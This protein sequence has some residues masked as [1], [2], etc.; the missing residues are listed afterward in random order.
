MNYYEI[1]GVDA[2][3][4]DVEIKKAYRKLAV[5]Y[6]PDVNSGDAANEEKFKEITMAYDTLSNKDKRLKYD[7]MLRY[8]GS[9]NSRFN[10]SSARGYEDFQDFNPEDI[11]SALFGFQKDNSI[12]RDLNVNL[13]IP[14][15]TAI[16]GDELKLSLNNNGK[17]KEVKIKIPSGV[18]SNQKLR[19]KN[20]GAV[21]TKRNGDL[22]INLLVE[23]DPNFFRNG[24]N[25]VLQLP[26]SI[27]EI[28]NGETIEVP[29]INGE[30]VKV[31]L[32]KSL[33]NNDKLKIKNLG[34]KNKKYGDL[35][36][37]VN[38]YL[39]EDI[40]EVDQREIVRLLNK[41]RDPKFREQIINE[42]QS[43]VQKY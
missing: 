11:F 25:L 39:M 17:Q 24:N 35:I 5:K 2:S 37:V 13:E 9:N 15:K 19:V 28:L 26:I 22:I 32:K 21:G 31:K 29:T 34:L 27:L 7:D 4:T 12:G 38:V 36:I 16:L 8:G 30:L 33:Q 43:Q 41:S 10:G 23:D 6:H 18:F 40:P 1:L 20:E 14:L 42:I 3:A